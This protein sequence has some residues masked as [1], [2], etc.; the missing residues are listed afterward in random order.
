MRLV[1]KNGN[2]NARLVFDGNEKCTT[3]T[4]NE[5]NKVISSSKS[6]SGITHETTYNYDANG[7][8]ITATDW[9]GNT[10]T[11]MYRKNPMTHYNERSN[12]D[13]RLKHI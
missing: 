12:Q 4:Y 13:R 6:A 11:A 1:P 8:Q 3:N 5:Q 2:G 9:L 7:N 10:T